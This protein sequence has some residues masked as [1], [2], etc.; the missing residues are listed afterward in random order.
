MLC[1][2]LLSRSSSFAL[3]SASPLS[4]VAGAS[5]AAGPSTSSILSSASIISRGSLRTLVDVPLGGPSLSSSSTAPPGTRLKGATLDKRTGKWK[6]AIT[7]NKKRISLGSF[8]T[9]KEASDAYFAARALYSDPLHGQSLFEAEFKGGSGKA[10][11]KAKK[12]NKDTAATSSSAA[13]HG[14]ENEEEDGEEEEEEL[15]SLGALRK[16]KASR[17]GAAKV[18][19]DDDGGDGRSSALAELVEVAEQGDAETG[20]TSSIKAKKDKKKADVQTPS[21]S[22]AGGAGGA[23]PSPSYRGVVFVP[24]SY[25]TTTKSLGVWEAVITLPAKPSEAPQEISGG[26]YDTPEEAAKAYDAL[27]LMYLGPDAAANL[28]FPL[29]P[30]ASWVPPE[31]ATFAAARGVIE[32]KPGVPLTVPEITASL[33]AEGGIDI[34]VID[35]AGKSDLAEHMVFVTGRDA[36]HMGQMADTLSRALRKRKL[37]GIDPT[38]EARDLDDWMIVDCGNIIV[39]VM[40]ADARECFDLEAMYERMVDGEDPEMQGLTYEEWLEKNPIPEKWLKRLEK[41]EEEIEAAARVKTGRN[42]PPPKW[43][44]NRS[45]SSGSGEAGIGMMEANKIL[46]V[47]A[48]LKR[49]RG[50]KKLKGGR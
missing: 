8:A 27:A 38:V 15:Q 37:K 14:E 3:S 32:A 29:D 42:A 16:K 31:E 48:S 35:L 43:T 36:R 9:E 18:D 7:V 20:S 40:D 23:S 6:S 11:K 50:T 4:A 10:G 34:N 39:N 1:R 25:N 21:A 2:R 17:R 24:D 49:K 19:D 26:D 12:A 47:G 44:S 46:N 13:N 41:D 28:N 30:A 5:G 45:N 22:A 33:K